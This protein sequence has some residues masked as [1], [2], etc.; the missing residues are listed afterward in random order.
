MRLVV[1]TQ[2]VDP[3]HPALAATVPKIRALCARADEVVVLAL[4]SVPA[5]LPAN[6]RVKTFGARTRLGRGLRFATALLPELLRRPR[7]AG[8][9]AHMCP[10]YAV[11][12]APVARP[13]GVP[14]VLWYTHWR[15]TAML[16]LAV[17]VSSRVISVDRRS[18]PISTAKVRGIGHGIDLAEFPF[19]EPRGR[20]GTLRA[21]SLGR[22]SAAKGL[23]A[24]LR[25]VR[26]ARAAGVDVSLDVRG[27]SLTTEERAHR[28]ELERLVVELRLEGCV[29]I[30]D[31]VSREQVPV[32]FASADV[33]VNNM[34]AGAPDKVV[35]EAGA[36]C[37]PVLASNPVFDELLGGFE[38]PLRFER[39]R[40]EQLAERLAALA[41]L[42][43][44]HRA[45]L[46]AALHDRVAA[47]HSV[48]SWADGALAA[49]HG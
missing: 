6:C 12:A 41:A 1:V 28:L 39:E 44:E 20:A 13:L 7:P 17:R 37:L 32:L 19:G 35:Y 33:L 23:S 27:P 24:V 4:G 43:P 40:P 26:L 46:G 34:R 9:L 8:V 16:R 14:V 3:A 22:T 10:V 49:L 21:L 47:G 36:A 25:A 42:S 31:A 15:S 38:P 2:H 5:S 30:G 29:T 11:L 48:E 18:V 45:E